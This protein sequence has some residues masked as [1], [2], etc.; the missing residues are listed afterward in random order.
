MLVELVP[1]IS[2]VELPLVLPVP[3]VLPVWPLVLD[4]LL[5]DTVLPFCGS[6][7]LALE[8]WAAAIPIENRAAVAIARS[9][10]DIRFS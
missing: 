6:V 8:L 3:A 2:E 4:W 7:L 9:F 1:L 5:V 10:L